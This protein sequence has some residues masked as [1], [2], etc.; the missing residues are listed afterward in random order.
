MTFPFLSF[1]AMYES[2]I[3]EDFVHCVLKISDGGSSVVA[4][5]EIKGFRI[6]VFE[7]CFLP[8]ISW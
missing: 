4:Y 8:L 1:D 5:G 3:W 2:I 7:S 6:D